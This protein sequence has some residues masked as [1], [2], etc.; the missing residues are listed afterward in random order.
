[1]LRPH[2]RM[3]YQ[4]LAFKFRRRNLRVTSANGIPR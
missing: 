4:I 3:R 1:V 2:N